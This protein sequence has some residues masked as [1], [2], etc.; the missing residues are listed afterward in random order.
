VRFLQWL[1]VSESSASKWN[2]RYAFSGGSVPA[3]AQV[4]SQGAR[5][6]PEPVAL[7]V[8]EADNTLCALDMACGRAGNAQYL[9][10]RGFRVSAWDV[11]DTVINEIGNRKPSIIHDAQVRDVVQRPPEPATF[12]VIV[13]ARFLDRT[14]CDDIAR[15]LKPGGLLFYQTFVHGLKN[16]AFLLNEN[17]LLDLFSTLHVLEYYEPAIDANGVAE[18]CLV[19]RRNA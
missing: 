2:A 4:L 7:T 12:D 10:E 8:P 5:W 6:L 9:A 11:S 18:A 15:A 13:V 16:P 17:E 14:V 3:P 19:A 1:R